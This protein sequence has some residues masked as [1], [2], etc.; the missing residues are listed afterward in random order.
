[1]RN[2]ATVPEQ[3]GSAAARPKTTSD[4][5]IIHTISLDWSDNIENDSL[6]TQGM[7]FV[8]RWPVPYE[9]YD[10]HFVFFVDSLSESV[11]GL[12]LLSLTDWNKMVSANSDQPNEASDTAAQYDEFGLDVW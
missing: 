8:D 7:P 3:E 1:M 10:G 12:T 2:T 6:I 9:C 4:V 5:E 11:A